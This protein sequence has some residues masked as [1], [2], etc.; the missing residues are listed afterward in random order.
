MLSKAPK[1][2][3]KGR[4]LSEEYDSTLNQIKGSNSTNSDPSFGDVEGMESKTL[5]KVPRRANNVYFQSQQYNIPQ[6]KIK[7]KMRRIS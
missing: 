6:P 1:R 5:S 3:E 2:T 7:L 4:K